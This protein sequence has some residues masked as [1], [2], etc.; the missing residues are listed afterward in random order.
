MRSK[1]AQSVHL[2]DVCGEELSRREL[3]I[4][5]LCR[6]ELKNENIEIEEESA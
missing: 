4:C 1:N 3:L 2:C 6:E 5:D